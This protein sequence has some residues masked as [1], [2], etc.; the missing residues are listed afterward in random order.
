MSLTRRRFRK[1]M[2]LSLG[3]CSLVLYFGPALLGRVMP[4]TVLSWVFPELAGALRAESLSLSW[5]RPLVGKAI[6]LRDDNDE[7]VIFIKE[8]TTSHSLLKWI[9]RPRQLGTFQ[10]NGL[11]ANLVVDPKGSHR[12]HT[13]PPADL[14]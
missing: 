14:R 7:N 12:L 10:A 8:L 13:L 3:L 1:R 2:V 9:S 6:A 5:H 11:Q 4:S